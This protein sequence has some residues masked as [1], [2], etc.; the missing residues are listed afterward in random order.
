MT[1]FYISNAVR[2]STPKLSILDE[3]V[4]ANT[5]IHA[6]ISFTPSYC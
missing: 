5:I 4:N 2:N 6:A 1:N 3:N